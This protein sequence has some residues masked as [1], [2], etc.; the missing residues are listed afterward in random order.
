MNKHS[1]PL[2]LLLTCAGTLGGCYAEGNS[3]FLAKGE[4]KLFLSLSACEEEATA[5]YSTGG[6]VYSGFECR[7]KFLMFTTETR[8]YGSGKR[9][10]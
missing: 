1:L 10:R 6:S 2:L 9:I 5:V 8:S 7:G 3:E 4:T